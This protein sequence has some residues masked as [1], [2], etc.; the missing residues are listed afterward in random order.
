MTNFRALERK[1][2]EEK[3]G[4]SGATREENDPKSESNEKRTIHATSRPTIFFI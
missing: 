4:T 2:Q 3:L 1:K